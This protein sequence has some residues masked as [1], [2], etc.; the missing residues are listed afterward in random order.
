M[1]LPYSPIKQVGNWYFIS[2][3]I[4]KNM[5]TH[6][7]PK[8][9][10][11]QTKQLFT[12]LDKILRLAGLNKTHVVK[13]TVFLADMGDFAAM[14]EVYKAYFAEPYPARSTVAVKELPRVADNALLVEIEA[15]A[16]K[17]SS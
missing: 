3:Q 4:G 12:N 15:V 11:K 6:T 10:T 17:A 2:G 7:A 14:N 16:H 1:N 5:E 8:D 9:I 13:A